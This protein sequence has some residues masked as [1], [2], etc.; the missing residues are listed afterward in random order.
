[1]EIRTTKL[2]GLCALYKIGCLTYVTHTNINTY[3]SSRYINQKIYE[4]LVPKSGAISAISIPYLDLGPIL[5]KTYLD[6]FDETPSAGNSFTCNY[7]DTC[8]EATTITGTYV[9]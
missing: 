8:G 3:Y 9:T 2:D 7:G 1:M 4:L 6:F 5:S